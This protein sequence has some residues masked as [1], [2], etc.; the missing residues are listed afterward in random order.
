MRHSPYGTQHSALLLL[1]LGVAL[2]LLV[3][4]ELADFLGWLLW[5]GWCLLGLHR[6]RA[7]KTPP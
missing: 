5:C 1:L 7:T 3:V 2:V 6:P 4:A